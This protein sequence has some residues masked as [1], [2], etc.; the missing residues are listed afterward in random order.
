MQMKSMR[1]LGWRRVLQWRAIQPILG[2]LLLIGAW[3][4][5][6]LAAGLEQTVEPTVT[7]IMPAMVPLAGASV[8]IERIL[9]L[10]WHYLE[11]G[12]MRFFRWRPSDLKTPSYVAFKRSTSLLVGIF[13]GI[14]VSN[15][16]G[17]RLMGYLNPLVPG[18]LDQIPDLW[19]IIVTGLL[20]G[21][22]AK[23]THDIL[24]IITQLK[25][26][27]GSTALKQREL[28]GAALADSILKL[29]QADAPS[30]YRVD[31]PGMGTTQVPGASAQTARNRMLDETDRTPRERTID[32]YANAIHDNLYTGS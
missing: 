5:L 27:I 1:R 18:F 25:H 22:G 4:E 8:G 24:G 15:Y 17:M 23:P 14:V 20:I 29:R 32:R 30:S 6:A 13:L 19:D 7:L 11:W 31:V 28:A 10:I 16:S 2:G 21:A 9:E 26:L 12:A 3:P